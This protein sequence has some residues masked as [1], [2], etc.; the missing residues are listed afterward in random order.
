M[1]S[2]SSGLQFNDEESF[3]QNV[4]FINEILLDLK[5]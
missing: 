2:L 3:K 5:K 1:W 4:Y